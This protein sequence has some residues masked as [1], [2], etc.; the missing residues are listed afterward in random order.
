MGNKWM[1][2]I[3]EESKQMKTEEVKN[4]TETPLEFKA[5]QDI[6]HVNSKLKKEEVRETKLKKEEVRETKPNRTTDLG[7]MYRRLSS[8]KLPQDKTVPEFVPPPPPLKTKTETPLE[9]VPPPPP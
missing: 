6:N 9:F 7:E 3:A 4:K 5:A 8:A 2:K 1:H